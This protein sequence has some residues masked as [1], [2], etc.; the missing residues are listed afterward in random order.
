MPEQSDQQWLEELAKRSG[1]TV[2]ETDLANLQGKHAEDREGFKAALEKQYGERGSNTPGGGDAPMNYTPSQAWSNSNSGG[3]LFPDW[4]KDLMTTQ[5]QQQ[6]A[7]QAENKSRADA[8]YGTL[9]QRAAQGLDVNANDPIIK[10][11]VDAFSAGGERSRRNYLSDLAERSGPLANLRG[12]QRMSAE[13]LGQGTSAFQAELMGRELGNRRAEIAQALA[14]QGAMLSGDQTRN[15]QQQLAAMDQAIKESGAQ[16]S[17]RSVDNQFTLGNRGLD[18]Q[19]ML[20]LGGL[21]LQRQ[22]LS[23]GNDQFLRQLALRQWELGD[24]SDR[25][26]AGIG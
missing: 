20:G 5:V 2:G 13:R 6:Q 8:L 11:Q 15:L 26:W 1:A 12:E 10:N 21:D 17:A 7:Q 24:N 4:Y 22:G 9:S 14:A 25:A 19:Q 23:Q 3:G 16:T 18:I